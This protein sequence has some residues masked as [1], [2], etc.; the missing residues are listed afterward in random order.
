[1]KTTLKFCLPLLGAVMLTACGGDSSDDNSGPSTV[2]YSGETG[3]AT[4]SSNN[5]DSLS[6]SSEDVVVRA[7]ESE[8]ASDD[9]DD[10]GSIGVSANTTDTDSAREAL[11]AAVLTVIQSEL[12]NTVTAATTTINGD[13]GGTLVLNS[14][15]SR[16]VFDFNNYCDD[17]GV[18]NG[19]LILETSTSGSTTTLVM[20]YDDVRI[21]EDGET[22]I[23][24]GTMTTRVNQNTGDLIGGE[25]NYV[26]SVDG[27]S[28]TSNGS[29]TCSSNF[30]CEYSQNLTGSN[31]TVYRINDLD[32]TDWGSY[33]DVS[34]TFY[35]PD[36]GYMELE[37]ENITSCSDGSIGSGEI[38]LSDSSN[39]LTIV[40]VGCGQEPSITLNGS[41][42]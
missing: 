12:A 15:D 20:T 8:T 32:V 28:I 31:G 5:A 38:S 3:P 39:E 16:A 14:S 35:H 4:I 37:A 34:A 42:L 11:Q 24:T 22:V 36:Y 17:G 33:Y 19:S 27:E 1:M 26:A 23:L 29:Y 25:W 6:S 13:C 10:F 18:I 7:I 30:A 9:L 21:S 41:S 2:S 40:F